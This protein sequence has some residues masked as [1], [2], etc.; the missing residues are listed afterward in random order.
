MNSSGLGGKNLFVAVHSS[1]ADFPTKDD[2]AIKSAV[3]ATGDKTELSIPNI[4]SGEYAVAVFADVNGNGKLDSNFIGVPKEPIGVS[5]DAKGRF[6]PPKFADA[7][8]KLGEGVTRQ[9]ITIK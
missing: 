5:R 6:G 9:T 1:A 2:K 7:A 3:I 4:A 8:F